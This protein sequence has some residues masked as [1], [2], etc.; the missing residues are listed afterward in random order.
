MVQ[1]LQKNIAEKFWLKIHVKEVFPIYLNKFE[2][3]VTH[4]FL[5]VFCNKVFT[6]VSHIHVITTKIALNFICWFET[7]SEDE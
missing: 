7:V 6:Y 5:I 2:I 3:D 4:L 1:K